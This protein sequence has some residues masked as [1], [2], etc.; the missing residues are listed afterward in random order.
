MSYSLL[1]LIALLT[2]YIDHIGAVFYI[3][4]YRHIGRISFVL[5]AFLVANGLNYTKNKREYIMNLFKFALISEIFYDFFMFTVNYPK[6]FKFL[7]YYK[8]DTLNSQNVLFTLGFGA[9][10]CYFYDFY[11]N[12]SDIYYLLLLSLSLIFPALIKAD[13]GIYGALSIFLF[14]LSKT[15]PQKLG[16]VVLF[17]FLKYM[18]FGL[19]SYAA[20]ALVGGIFIVLYND[21]KGF[22]Q[23]N[24]YIFYLFYPLHMLFLALIIT[25][26]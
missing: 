21:K 5:Y 8:L 17:S 10:A 23:L 2:M 3:D 26:I 19:L 25:F 11:K 7:D 13:Y 18:Y 9:L 20:F 14:Y 22:L 4:S 24:K 12:K 16:V 1:K 6:Y 15:K